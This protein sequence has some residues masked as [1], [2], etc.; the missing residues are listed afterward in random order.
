MKCQKI[1]N[2]LLGAALM[3]GAT[4]ASA[5]FT[6][7]FGENLTPA[8][9]VTGDPVTARANFLSAL[10]GGVGNEDFEGESGSGPLS[11]SFPGSTGSIT[12]T[13]AGSGNIQS[14]P[15]AGRFATSGTNYWESTGVFTISFSSAISAFGFYA[16]DIGDFNGQVTL[17][18]AGGLAQV[19][20]IGNTLNG[21]NGSLLFYGFTD[22]T[23]AY[24][25]IA[26][27]NTNAG[28]D[29]FGF[30]DM[31]IGDLGQIIAVPEPGMLG[32]MAIGLLGAGFASKRRKG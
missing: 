17:T 19:I 15:G 28:T 10:S 11:L 9:T 21:P 16:T 6:T 14:S 25:S 1:A 31:V 2:I 18:T 30:D 29:F 4:T 24:T 5:A 3:T 8:S 12:A 23:N 26:F 7:Y 13:L 32:L 20:N 22:T 27:G